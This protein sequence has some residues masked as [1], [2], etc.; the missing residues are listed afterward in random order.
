[1]T[2]KSSSIRYRFTT[3]F[4][5]AC[6]AYPFFSGCKNWSH[7]GYLDG[8]WQVMEVTYADSLIEFPENARFYYNFYL[9]TFQLSTNNDRPE[10]LIGNMTYETH[11]DRLY[12]E[13]PR[14]Q[15]GR[16]SKKWLDMLVYW[17]V[18]KSGEMDVN[19]R[20]LSPSRLVMEYDS[21]V[22]VCRKF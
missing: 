14:I 21:V 9:H 2:S 16:V 17:G 6:L 10:G 13:L 15:E 22:I 8:M 1:M 20:Q 4:V 3:I 19:I 5:V 18:S 11:Q 7:N 12:L